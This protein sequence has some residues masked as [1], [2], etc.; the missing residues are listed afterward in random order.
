M[1]LKC[2]LGLV[3]CL[4]V[5]GE[6]VTAQTAVEILDQCEVVKMM[7]SSE[8]GYGMDYG[9]G[10]ASAELLYDKGMKFRYPHNQTPG[11]RKATVVKACHEFQRD[12]SDDSKWDN[13]DKWPWKR[14]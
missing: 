5:N 14:K 9:Y 3:A 8:F 1:P 7:S 13:L 11:I 10:S 2:M 4:H 12:F 6:I